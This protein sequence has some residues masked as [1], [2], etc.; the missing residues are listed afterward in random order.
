M[1]FGVSRLNCLLISAVTFGLLWT[2]SF[3]VK[4]EITKE[5]HGESEIKLQYK[6]LTKISPWDYQNLKEPIVQE[7]ARESFLSSSEL[8]KRSSFLT[9]I[10][11]EIYYF[12]EKYKV[13]KTYILP[14]LNHFPDHN[15]FDGFWK[16]LDFTKLQN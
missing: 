12:L 16:Q 8:S 13:A 11:D 5:E 7:K 15:I 4:A 6:T 14:E 2:V 10:N 3:S 9:Q 1:N